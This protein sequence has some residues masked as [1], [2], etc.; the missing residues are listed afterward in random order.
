M[1]WTAERQRGAGW[2]GVMATIALRLGW[3]A[4]YALLYP[5]TLVYLASSPA[6]MRRASRH[7]LGRALGRVP[8]LRD[9]W[10][11]YFAF[12]AT[13]LDR[14][15]LL[16]GRTAGYAITIEGLDTMRRHAEAGRGCIL[17]GAHFGSFDALRSIAGAGAP[18]EIRILMHRHMADAAHAM[19]NAL[20]PSRA[21]D[22]ISLG[23]PAA[24]IEAAECLARGG[25]IGILG[26]RAPRGERMLR[27]PFLGQEAP[28][29]GGPL[30]LA[31]ILGAPVMLCFGTWLGPRRYALRFEA[32]AERV[33]LDRA[34]RDA[35]LRDWL[36]RYAARLE[37][38][39]RAHPFNWF[40]FYDFWQEQ[41]PA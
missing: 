3:R 21:R 36:I 4:A 28:F 6:R 31:A 27:V 33:T 14:A 22:V 19:F 15:Y 32:F 16:T 20:D 7:Y 25:V 1:S 24:M 35:A 38:M 17:L 26:D 2:L 12:A 8:G 34:A 37:A 41:Q 10:R 9:M 39:C 13:L 5:V 11:L 23:N 29:P 40:N 18:V 30:Q